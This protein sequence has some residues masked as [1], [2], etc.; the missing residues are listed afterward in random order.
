MRCAIT[1]ELTSGAFRQA[2]LILAVVPLASPGGLTA[3]HMLAETLNVATAVG[4]LALFGVAVQNGIIVVANLNRVSSGGSPA[5]VVEGPINKSMF[6][7]F[8]N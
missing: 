3:I 2:I 6:P 1:L 8:W 7:S 4:F 5:P